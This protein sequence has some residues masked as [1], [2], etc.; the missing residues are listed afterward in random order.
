MPKKPRSEQEVQKVRE[1]ILDKT[2]ELINEVGYENFTMRKLANKLNMTATPIYQY[3]KNKDELYLAALAQGFE[4]L[5]AVAQKAREAGKDPMEKLKFVIRA[6][7]LYGLAHPG[8]YNILF[9]SSVP[10]Y[11]DYV[12]TPN[13][14]AAKQELD[15]A[16]RFR[17][18][19]VEVAEDS[20]LLDEDAEEGVFMKLLSGMCT[21]HGYVTLVNSQITDYLLGPL[22]Q[23]DSEELIDYLIDTVLRNYQK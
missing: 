2:L 19:I 15:A 10:K 18:L 22:V 3:Y 11:Y 20:G 7:V 4:T 13:E 16:M 21:I 5:C 9:V 12:G 14:E 8:V 23:T 6:L 1:E 17:D